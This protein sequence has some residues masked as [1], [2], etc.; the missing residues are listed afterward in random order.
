MCALHAVV[1][2]AYLFPNFEQ[3]NGDLNETRAPGPKTF[4]TFASGV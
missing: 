1:V 4:R 2:L 3:E